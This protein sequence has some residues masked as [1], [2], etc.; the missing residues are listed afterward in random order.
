MAGLAAHQ[1]RR[2]RE[3]AENMRRLPPGI[4]EELLRQ[5]RTVRQALQPQFDA[6]ARISMRAL[7]AYLRDQSRI[8]GTLA[9]A[10]LNLYLNMFDRPAVPIHYARS[11]TDPAEEVVVMVRDQIDQAT[12]NLELGQQIRVILAFAQ[13]EFIVDD[14]WA[15]DGECIAVR[16]FDG[17]SFQTVI[18]SYSS[19]TVLLEIYEPLPTTDTVH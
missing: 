17:S 15:E 5:N 7:Q 6:T 11:R 1:M 3:L 9:A 2:L 18:V 14:F 4:E 12:A 19:F 8:L 10:P 16:V 13:R